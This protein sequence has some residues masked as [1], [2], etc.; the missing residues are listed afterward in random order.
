MRYFLSPGGKDALVALT[1]PCLWTWLCSLY[2]DVSTHPGYH[3][4]ACSFLVHFLRC[5]W[6]VQRRLLQLGLGIQGS[7][8][9]QILG[10]NKLG[11]A[12][13]V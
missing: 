12:T 6:D 7:Y 3:A 5:F 2:I 13:L 8:L 4:V 1:W 11:Y 10:K 9:N